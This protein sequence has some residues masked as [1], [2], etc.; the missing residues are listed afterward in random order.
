MDK[1]TIV[2]VIA[3]R[4]HLM[5]FWGE[6]VTEQD[7]AAALENRGL[8]EEVALAA[9]LGSLYIHQLIVD[10]Q[11]KI[12]YLVENGMLEKREEK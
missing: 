6:G 11:E 4:E 5:A 10:D 8:T 7:I 9:V 1:A 2:L 3:K 12:G